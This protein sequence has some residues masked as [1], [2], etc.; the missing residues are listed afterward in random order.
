MITSGEDIKEEGYKIGVCKE[1][2]EL[3]ANLPYE[4]DRSTETGVK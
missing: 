1:A 2:K 3:I 4:A